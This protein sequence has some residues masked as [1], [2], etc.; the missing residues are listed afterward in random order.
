MPNFE[1][2]SSFYFSRTVLPRR[3]SKSQ[4]SYWTGPFG[5]A[6]LPIGVTGNI[7]PWFFHFIFFLGAWNKIL[8]FC[9]TPADGQVP[10]FRSGSHWS[11]MEPHCA[12]RHQVS[13]P[14]AEIMEVHSKSANT[15]KISLGTAGDFFSYFFLK[16]SG[17]I[18]V[19]SLERVWQ[20]Y[21]L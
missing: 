9:V 13:H 2:L 15:T 21:A 10:L 5:L 4:V 6:A 3:L 20:R 1:H 8:G 14:A 18:E 19:G 11:L 7:N 16:L 17:I 12:L